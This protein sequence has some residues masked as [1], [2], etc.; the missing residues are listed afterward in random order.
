[1]SIAYGCLFCLQFFRRTI[2]QDAILSLSETPENRLENGLHLVFF[3]TNSS[4]V[5][6]ERLKRLIGMTA[7]FT[8]SQTTC[9]RNTLKNS[10]LRGILKI[11]IFADKF[12]EAPKY[13]ILRALNIRDFNT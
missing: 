3:I 11:S 13:S 6:I 8:D 2:L 12:P 9:K 5:H 10:A 1:M 7:L 4:I